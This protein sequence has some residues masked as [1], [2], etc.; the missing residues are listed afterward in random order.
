[1]ASASEWTEIRLIGSQAAVEGTVRILRQCGA[2]IGVDTGIS[3]VKAGGDGK[4]R[5]HLTV[6]LADEPGND[7]TTDAP[8]EGLD[9]P[10]ADRG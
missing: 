9:L 10:E 2:E 5:R 3:R 7:N 8:R 1:M 4:V 6:R